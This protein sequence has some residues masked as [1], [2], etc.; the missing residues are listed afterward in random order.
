MARGGAAL[1]GGTRLA[2]SDARQGALADLRTGMQ[3][4]MPGLREELRTE[5]GLL[6][7]RITG[8]ERCW[9]RGRSGRARNRLHACGP[10]A[11]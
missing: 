11:G 5:I 1:R 3:T 9:S 7:E 6:E 8:W 4:E 2:E 10:R